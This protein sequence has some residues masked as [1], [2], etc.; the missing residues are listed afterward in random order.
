MKKTKEQV[1]KDR[2]MKGFANFGIKKVKVGSKTYETDFSHTHCWDQ[3]QPSACGIPLE[4]H[5]QCCL[6][7]KKYV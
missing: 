5:E 7:P 6:C 3:K 4:E 1:L 2:A